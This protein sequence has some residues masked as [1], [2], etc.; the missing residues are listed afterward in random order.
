VHQLKKRLR[1]TWMQRRQ[2][3]EVLQTCFVDSQG[4]VP[5]FREVPVERGLPHAGATGDAIQGY[6]CAVTDEQLRKSREYRP[7]I[8]LGIAP[9][10]W[11]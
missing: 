11:G 2:L 6:V 1:I 9:S 3:V 4:E 7:A 8:A 5:A 10:A